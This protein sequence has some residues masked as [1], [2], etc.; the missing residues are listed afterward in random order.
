[1]PNEKGGT[2]EKSISAPTEPVQLVTLKPILIMPQIMSKP[3]PTI[4]LNMRGFDDEAISE[5]IVNS[6]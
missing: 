4:S 6:V 2:Q 1:M 3:Q 5:E